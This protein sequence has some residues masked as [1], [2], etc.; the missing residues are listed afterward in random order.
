MIIYWIIMNGVCE[1][2]RRTVTALQASVFRNMT[3]QA[4]KSGTNYVKK[5]GYD[6][7]DKAF[8]GRDIVT[9]GTERTSRNSFEMHLF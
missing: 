3:L 6:N 7:V 1:T 8:A 4:N 9:K 2:G 5:T